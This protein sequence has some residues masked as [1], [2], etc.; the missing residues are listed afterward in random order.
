MWQQHGEALIL[1]GIDSYHFFIYEN[2]LLFVDMLM[3]NIKALI[4]KV[5]SVCAVVD[6]EKSDN[7]MT[8]TGY[9]P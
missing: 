4:V 8:P 7:K 3:S 9:L 6:A 1:R 2:E 5:Y